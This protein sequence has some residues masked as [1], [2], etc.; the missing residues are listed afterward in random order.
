MDKEEIEKI[1]TDEIALMRFAFKYL[2]YILMLEET[3]TVKE[4]YKKGKHSPEAEGL[5]PE[6]KDEKK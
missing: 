1:K 5:V 6:T 3:L 4:E 2:K